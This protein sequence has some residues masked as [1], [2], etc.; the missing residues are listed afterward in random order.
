MKP[1]SDLSRPESV[2]VA[3]VNDFDV[4]VDGVLGLLRESP[5]FTAVVDPTPDAD[6]DV[7]VLDTYGRG[8]R[9]WDEFESLVSGHPDRAAVIYAFGVDRQLTDEA[10]GRG[11]R[12]VIWKGIDGTTFLDDLTRI[13]RGETVVDLPV[14]LSAPPR[15]PGN[16]PF[17]ETGLSLRESEVLAH[18]AA[19]R[20]NREIAELLC[21]SSETVKT[22]V[23]SVLRKLGV[24]NRTEATWKALQSDQFARRRRPV[25]VEP[26]LPPSA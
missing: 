25:L 8:L 16:W 24:A 4:I 26:A 12:G 21:V 13:A 17:R 18:V 10:L 2:R 11:A 1:V 6:A 22:H 7:I 15:P 9:P 23:R 20:S 19:G 3:V 14:G 5:S